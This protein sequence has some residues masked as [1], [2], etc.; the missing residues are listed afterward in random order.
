VYLDASPEGQ[1]KLAVAPLSMDLDPMA[2]GDLTLIAY[3]FGH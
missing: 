3:I 2:Q 1:S